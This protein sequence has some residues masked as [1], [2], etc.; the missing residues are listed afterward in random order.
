MGARKQSKNE[1]SFRKQLAQNKESSKSIDAP[2]IRKHVTAALESETVV[3]VS[4]DVY[5]E[6]D[7]VPELTQVTTCKTRDAAWLLP[8]FSLLRA[9]NELGQLTTVHIEKHR[10]RA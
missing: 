2:A 1:N 3:C 10:G 8:G 4:V 7:I 5:P 9:T 6:S